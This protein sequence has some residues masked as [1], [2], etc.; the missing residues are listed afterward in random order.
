MESAIVNFVF[1]DIVTLSG[2]VDGKSSG[3]RRPSYTEGGPKE[4][5]RLPP[6]TSSR[7]TEVYREKRNIGFQA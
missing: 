6:G 5:P 1:K 2:G 7:T 4:D 3:S